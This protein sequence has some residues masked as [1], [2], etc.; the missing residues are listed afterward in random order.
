MPH[1]V[2]VSSGGRRHAQAGAAMSVPT[3]ATSSQ[4][5]CGAYDEVCSSQGGW[6]I[7]TDAL[8]TLF[9]SLEGLDKTVDRNYIPHFVVGC[10]VL[11]V[12][13]LVFDLCYLAVSKRSI[14]RLSHGWPFT[15]V[16]FVAWPIGAAFF[17]WAALM[18]RIIQPTVWGAL[19]AAFTWNAAATQMIEKLL[20]G[21]EPLE[22]PAEGEEP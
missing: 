16:L 14:L 21:K 5:K 11:G 18:L 2:L 13:A 22:D 9:F 7:V 19:V 3:P 20:Q 17:G 4:S 6:S 1:V 12:A 15:I 10:L 8:Y